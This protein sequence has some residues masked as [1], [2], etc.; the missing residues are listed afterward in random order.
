MQRP[1]KEP[2]IYSLDKDGVAEGIT[3]V[4]P[5]ATLLTDTAG[6]VIDVTYNRDLNKAFAELYNAIISIGGNI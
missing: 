3:S 5:N 2:I 4:Y 6:A 1:Y